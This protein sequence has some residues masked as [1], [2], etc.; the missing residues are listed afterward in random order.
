VPPRHT[1]TI[2]L[3]VIIL[4]GGHYVCFDLAKVLLQG[5]TTPP[6]HHF[7]NC[8]YCGKAA[9]C[10][11][12]DLA[13]VFFQDATTPPYTI[14]YLSLLWE[15]G[16]MLL[17]R[18]SQGISSGCHHATHTPKNSGFVIIA[19]RGHYASAPT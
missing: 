18:L 15:G 6:L 11:C 5:A 13:T 17:L 7:F 19:G 8:H 12:F 4:G 3:I 9:L 10:F 2:F 1:C 14:F 16:I